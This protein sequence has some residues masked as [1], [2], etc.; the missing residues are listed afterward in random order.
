M[1]NKKPKVLMFGTLQI[2]KWDNG[3]F[4]SFT[5]EKRYK[6]KDSEEWQS[7]NSLSRDDLLKLKVLIDEIL[8][9]DIKHL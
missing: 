9:E 5:I 6:P 8:R 4:N 7:T 3:D 2:K 1:E